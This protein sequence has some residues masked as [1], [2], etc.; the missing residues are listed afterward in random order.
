MFRTTTL[1]PLHVCS[2]PKDQPGQD[3]EEGGVR[4]RRWKPLD[5]SDWHFIGGW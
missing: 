1:D 4:G 5:L 2:A 3:M